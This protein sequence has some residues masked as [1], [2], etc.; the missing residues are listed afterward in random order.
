MTSANLT[1]NPPE[2]LPTVGATETEPPAAQ[3]PGVSE[4]DRNATD[5]AYDRGEPARK[6]GR[7]RKSTWETC[8]EC[9][10]V[11]ERRASING[12]TLKF[13][14]RACW[15]LHRGKHQLPRPGRRK[16]V[17]CKCTICGIEFERKL[18]AVEDKKL[19]C[20]KEC[21]KKHQ[22]ILFPN[23]R[24][25]GCGKEFRG[26]HLYQRRYCSRECSDMHR[27]GNGRARQERQVK[28]QNCGNEFTVQAYQEGVAK[29][30]SRKCQREG[31]KK[32]IHCRCDQCG[33]DFTKRP[34]EM[35]A[36]NYCSKLCYQVAITNVR[37]QVTARGKCERCGWHEEVG[38]LRIHH[39]NRDRENNTL[40]NLELLCP[41]CHDLDHFRS[42][43]GGWSKIGESF[44]RRI[45]QSKRVADY[46]QRRD[47]TLVNNTTEL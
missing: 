27:T 3:A 45:R 38:I 44:H 40:E 30:C 12:G 43:D 24:C 22:R 20:S 6:L 11:Y 9:G 1:E 36:K 35:M 18:S 10:K 28:C 31:F 23:G 16:R 14:S 33:K 37:E 34:S 13:C 17:Q 8:P 4:S 39:K 41:T 15:N 2:R 29:F 26:S 47:D 19:F 5:P 46:L 32:T 7:P 21:F 42:G 25:A